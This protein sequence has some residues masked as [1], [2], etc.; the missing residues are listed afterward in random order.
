MSIKLNLNNLMDLSRNISVPQYNQ[1]AI[2]PGIVHIGVGN[3]HRAHQAVYLNRL[4]NRGLDHDWGIVGAGVMPSDGL[5]RERLEKQDW[6]STIVE[7][8]PDG[9][10]ASVCGSMIGFAEVSAEGIIGWLTKPEIRIVSLT[11]TEG[12]YFLDPKTGGFDA[13][14]PLIQEDIA[15]PDSPKTVFGSIVVALK[16][17][18]AL[19]YEP[20]TVMSCDNV[21]ENGTVAKRAVLGVATL[22]A[23]ELVDWITTSV[24]FPNSMVDCI[25]PATGERER[26]IAMEHFGVEDASVVV[27]EPFRQW[28][29]ED[30]FPQGRPRLEDVGVEFVQDVTPFELMKLRILN[31][32]HAAIAY[33]SALLGY[34]YAHEAMRVPLIQ[35]FLNKLEQDEIIPTVP[36]VPGVDF[37]S[38][39]KQTMMRFSNAQIG[40]RISR[41]C[42]DGSNR[43]PKFI[44]PTIIDRLTQG[45]SIKGLALEVAL[46]CRYCTGIDEAGR[47]LVVEDE[48][49]ERLREKACLAQSDP[50]AFIGM[51]DIFGALSTDPVFAREFSEVLGS[52]WKNGTAFTL[53]RYVNGST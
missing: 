18:K 43:Q 52:L 44:F 23:P 40:D 32:G 35:A 12:G 45:L 27:C 3:F 21:P 2:S 37:H 34:E 33:A 19:G 24:A 48:N 50:T 22:M 49:A 42:L 53:T 16:R 9:Y 29:L 39:L 31:G 47:P 51:A 11:V 17:R 8:D 38:Y 41:L 7:L 26:N 28:V 13:G 5:M 10:T 6:L 25:T 46:W 1:G 15:M 30:N 4:F 36:P 20:F 14:H